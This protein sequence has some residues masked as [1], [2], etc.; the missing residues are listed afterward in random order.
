MVLGVGYNYKD[1]EREI[2][3]LDARDFVRTVLNEDYHEGNIVTLWALRDELCS[4]DPVLLMD[5]DVLYD[6][7][8]MER[9]VK[10]RHQNCLLIDRDF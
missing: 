2:A 7:T 10:L 8:L 3:A 9:L 6:E 5:A 4:G 1:I